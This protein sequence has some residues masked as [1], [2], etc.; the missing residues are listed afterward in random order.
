MAWSCD[1]LKIRK[2]RAPIKIKSALLPPPPK[3][4][5]PPPPKTRNFMDIVFPAERTHFF[6]AFIKFKVARLQSEFRTKD[7]LLS[8]EFSYEKCPEISPDFFEP[9][10][11]GSEKI[12]LNSR[13]NSH[14]ISQIS[15]RKINKISPT[16]FC[17]SARRN[18]IGAPISG[19][20]IADTNFT[21]TRIFLIR[22]AWRFA[23]IQRSPIRAEYAP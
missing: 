11:C 19:P 3:S 12:P 2:I 5:I 18:K 15:L 10:F 9:L 13:Q 16:S 6:R 7:F 23:G 4:K 21:D 1:C 14:Q 22:G 20:R 17:R 8:Y